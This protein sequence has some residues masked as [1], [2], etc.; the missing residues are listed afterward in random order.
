M[1]PQEARADT[2]CVRGS[3]NPGGSKDEG[4][5]IAAG[6]NR[7]HEDGSTVL[8]KIVMIALHGVSIGIATWVLVGGGVTVFRSDWTV[9]YPIRARLMLVGLWLVWVKHAVSLKWIIKRKVQWDEAVPLALFSLPCEVGMALLSTGLDGKSRPAWPALP[10]GGVDYAAAAVF[11]LGWGVS[12]WAEVDRMLWKR[13]PAHKGKCYT[14]GLWRYSAHINYFGET[15]MWSALA[16]LTATWWTAVLPLGMAAGFVWYHIPGLD[17]YLSQR[18]GAAFD[19]Y[20][21][22]TKHFIPFVY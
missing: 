8:P 14:E 5:Y 6:V 15:L 18:Y 11:A 1:G 16:A 7:G 21:A 2:A 10:V 9:H 19:R 22:R 4:D 3:P 17:A 12:T 20:C 13:D